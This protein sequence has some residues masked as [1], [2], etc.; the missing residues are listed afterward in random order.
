MMQTLGASWEV[1][2]CDLLKDE[3]EDASLEVRV[4][5]A[6]LRTVPEAMRAGA[7]AIAVI[8]A[9][10]GARDPA[11]ATRELLAALSEPESV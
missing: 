11:A 4:V 10:M 1:K 9:V 6:S 2:L 3:F 8:G 5:T 7:S